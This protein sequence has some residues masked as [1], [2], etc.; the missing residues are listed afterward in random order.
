MTDEDH[1]R[2]QRAIELL[3]QIMQLRRSIK[4]RPTA[5]DTIEQA[6]VLGG[7]F[8]RWRWMS[9]NKGAESNVHQKV[10]S[11][12]Q[13]NRHQGTPEEREKRVEW[14]RRRVEELVN[15]D[16]NRTQGRHRTKKEIYQDVGN[17]Q[18][19]PITGDAVKKLLYR[20][21]KK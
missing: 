6:L 16:K 15:K 8:E 7:L 12:D 5:S 20:H 2:Y 9:F 4:N 10:N 14:M 13:L 11:R 21:L 1:W 3:L 18:N 17:E 19:P